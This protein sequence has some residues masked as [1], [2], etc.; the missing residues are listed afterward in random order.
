M[1]T[2]PEDTAP[3]A[4]ISTE[5]FF[6]LVPYFEHLLD[7]DTRGGLMDLCWDDFFTDFASTAS[8]DAVVSHLSAEV[9]AG[10][11][12]WTEAV[13]AIG[14][15]NS[16]DSTTDSTDGAEDLAVTPGATSGV[17]VLATWLGDHATAWN[18]TL[19]LDDKT[20]A[21]LRRLIA[22]QAASLDGWN[23]LVLRF[24]RQGERLDYSVDRHEV[25]DPEVIFDESMMVRLLLDE[26]PSPLFHV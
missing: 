26:R 19:P 4:S 22:A 8:V 14:F 9:L 25:A 15:P 23:L 3:L 12:D 1:T 10:L 18:L 6:A 17:P 5:E 7:A 20:T 11:P 21:L 2:H 24:S 13:V 16:L